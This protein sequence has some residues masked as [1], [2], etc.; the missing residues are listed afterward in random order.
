[1]QFIFSIFSLVGVIGFVVWW[2]T[3]DLTNEIPPTSPSTNTTVEKTQKN[4][5]TGPI[6]QAYDAK[7]AIESRY[8]NALN[9]SSQGLTKV[10]TYVFER[11]DLESLN[12]SHNTLTGAL[13]GEIRHLQNLK[14]LDMSN[15]TFT[16]IPAEIGQL[17]N[18]EIL[19]LSNNLLTGLPYEIGN[20]ARLKVLDISG[21]AYSETDLSVIKKL[22]PV[23]VVITTD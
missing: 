3:Q 10:P 22:L 11:T 2:S 18:L 4:G 9:L 14:V 19:N 15:N 21:N 12:L 5:I 23:S 6:E 16:G 1:M 8:S 13:P 17:K 7:N 20:L